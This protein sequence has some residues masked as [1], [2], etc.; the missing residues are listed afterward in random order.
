MK[1]L[2]T[3]ISGDREGET[4]TLSDMEC[5]TFGRT[6]VCDLAFENDFHMSSR[7]FK[8][9]NLG[10][11]GEVTDLGSTN[12]TWL[13]TNKITSERLREG[14]R[15]RAGTTILTVE[16]IQS[17]A[18]KSAPDP[19]QDSEP[20]PIPHMQAL[21]E[22]PPQPVDTG[23][24]PTPRIPLSDS[25]NSPVQPSS[26]VP[27]QPLPQP[28]Q[29]GRSEERL[30]PFGDS[31][32]FGAEPSPQH[33]DSHESSPLD[34]LQPGPASN[35]HSSFG[36][37][38]SRAPDNPF[39]DSSFNMQLPADL[40]SGGTAQPE[41]NVF[42]V[43]QRHT[44]SESADG[45][46]VI[47]D[48]LSR[49]WSIQLILH[50]QKVRNSP[51]KLPGSRT[52]FNWLPPDAQGYSPI[53]VGWH[54]VSQAPNVASLLPRLCKADG[55]IA[56]LG[57]SATEVSVQIDN[58]QTTGVEGFSEPNGFLPLYWPSS[59]ATML[60]CR[61]VE[62]CKDLFQDKVSGVLMCSP[63]SRNCVVS[64]ANSELSQD[65]LATDFNVTNNMIGR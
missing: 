25:H 44:S 40:R 49:K 33:S 17:P 36:A 21:D 4:I 35:S 5:V 10:D 50:F 16:F 24:T 41:S 55:C 23:N 58:M 56:L 54:E 62:L 32:D 60:D 6:Q 29:A 31:I 64:A 11:Y 27:L 18:V 12:G 1:L 3:A 8:V 39:G 30:T 47:L 19:F 2:L 28:N 15:I 22:V 9:A 37:T 13:N 43:L 38:N 51:P 26:N 48:T 34:A 57:K 42:Q 65:L 45:F 53:Q 61:G 7:H 52:L 59:L 46:S 63:W 20:Q 14:D